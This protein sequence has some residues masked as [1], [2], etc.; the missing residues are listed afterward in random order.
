MYLLD[1]GLLKLALSTP[2][3]AR[4]T[5]YLLCPCLNL[6]GIA[7][8]IC[9][10]IWI[11]YLIVHTYLISSSYPVGAASVLEFTCQTQEENVVYMRKY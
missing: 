10:Y 2:V 5:A 3:F 1:D 6:W 7:V 4:K 9:I 11:I 8:V